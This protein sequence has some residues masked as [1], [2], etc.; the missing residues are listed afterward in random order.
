MMIL[1]YSDCRV[2][3]IRGKYV[4]K[5]YLAYIDDRQSCS[6]LLYNIKM[7]C[8]M[9]LAGPISNLWGKNLNSVLWRAS[10]ER[11][12]SNMICDELLFELGRCLI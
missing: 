8:S 11:Q 12:V 2:F 9:Y 4:G 6:S 10:Q 5:P 1:F 7:I 3:D